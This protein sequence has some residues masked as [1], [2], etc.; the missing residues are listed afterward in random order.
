MASSAEHATLR[1]PSGRSSPRWTSS[2]LPS[3][4]DMAQLTDILRSTVLPTA[5]QLDAF[6]RFISE[7]PADLERYDAEIESI[8][9]LL[10]RFKSERELLSTYTDRCRSVHSPIRCMPTELL[11][12]IFD[13]CA[14]S[15]AESIGNEDTADMEV[16]RL[17][18][19]HLLQ[20]SSV[21]YRWYQTVMGSPK[22]WSTIVIDAELWDPTDIRT[23]H[24]L[25]RLKLSLERGANSP[26]V[27]QLGLPRDDQDLESSILELVTPHAT[28]WRDVHL[29][30]NP[31][32]VKLLAKMRGNLPRLESLSLSASTSDPYP[33][34]P[35]VFDLAPRLRNLILTGWPSRPEIPW[36]QLLDVRFQNDAASVTSGLDIL[37]LLQRGAEYQMDWNCTT[38][39]L[40]SL[41]WKPIVS[42]LSI[43]TIEFSGVIDSS[44]PQAT[45]R[46]ML[47]SVT[48][49][50][51]RELYIRRDPAGPPSFWPHSAF[52][53][54]T[55]RS[56]LGMCLTDLQIQ[57]A[58]Q[59]R[60]LIQ[61]LELL[62]LLRR[63]W[64]RDCE[65]HNRHAVMT[66]FLFDRLA[67]TQGEPDIVPR[68]EYC[69]F[70]PILR[71]SDESLGRFIGF[72]V[73]SGQ[74]KTLNI[75]FH[76]PLTRER[77]FSPE[78]LVQMEKWQERKEFRFS[79]HDIA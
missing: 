1:V 3:T 38:V 26:L 28:R 32:S 19:T 6:R 34:G 35:A 39:S 45:L 24:L 37:S 5:A 18:K 43:F 31:S 47:E 63:L 44:I 21:C 48:M 57:A 16:E 76:L 73:A 2:L 53:S 78:F 56:L 52:L 70:R 71:C 51:L 11:I 25:R 41:V 60:E 75:Q 22:L 10:E 14:P 59:D 58:I 17:A 55:K 42:H 49:P 36:G 23:D 50:S 30:I 67:C 68:L 7:A 40:G 29:W 27:M 72:R 33:P 12:E 61:C 66:D 46:N 74:V 65:D 9:L 15:C 64:L 79:I 20:L 62:P 8:Q 13:M 69:Y 54:F 4:T 77:A